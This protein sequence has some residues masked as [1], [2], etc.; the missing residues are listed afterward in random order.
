MK[1]RYKKLL[2]V[3]L[4]TVLTIIVVFL[5]FSKDIDQVYS[6]K[7]DNFER[8]LEELEAEQ[9]NINQKLRAFYADEDQTYVIQSLKEEKIDEVEE[10][11]RLFEDSTSSLKKDLFDLTTRDQRKYTEKIEKSDL[12][13]SVEIFYISIHDLRIKKELTHLVNRLFT[14]EYMED[15]EVNTD[16]YVAEDLNT[17]QFSKA[18]NRLNEL[19]K[20]AE[21][22]N[23]EVY[24]K[25]LM[26]G[27]EIAEQQLNIINRAN[28]LYEEL[29]NENGF[30]VVTDSEKTEE[31]RL[32]VEKIKN[33]KIQD[34]F[35]EYLRITEKYELEEQEET[36]D[37]GETDSEEQETTSDSGPSNIGQTNNNPSPQ[38]GQSNKKPSNQ[39]PASNQENSNSKPTPTPEP[40]QLPE[41][42]PEASEQPKDPEPGTETPEDQEPNTDPET[43][44]DSK[45][46]DSDSE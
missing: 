37:V 16:V 44:P 21:L 38:R 2:A 43:K 19:L 12:K 34:T 27:F 1:K 41:P 39:K 35:D 32:V 46:E 28:E 22:K 25:R 31:F 5:G 40:E 18:K 17:E 8:H 33:P 14:K 26:E 36:K 7:V 20:A 42:N 6:M 13:D 9:E 15:V 29:F 4:T 30:L 23:R 45:P 11:V 3:F 10:I 24:L